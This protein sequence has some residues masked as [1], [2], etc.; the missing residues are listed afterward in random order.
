RDW[1]SDVCSSDLD[2]PADDPRPGPVLPH[3][4]T[5]RS[6]LPR[7]GDRRRGSRDVSDA[8]NAGAASEDLLRLITDRHVVVCTG[9]GGVGKTTISAALAVRAADLGRK[10][11]VCTIDPAKRLAQSLGLTE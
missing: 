7:R 8:V 1:S 10:T 11:I 5:L 3:H 4:R 6:R 2:R 9:P